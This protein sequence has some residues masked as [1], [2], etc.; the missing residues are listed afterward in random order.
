V[1]IH[2][3]G[4]TAD[5]SVHFHQVHLDDMVRVRVRKDRELEEREVT[6]GEIGKGYE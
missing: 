5:H 2:V 4:A 6:Q 1:P 3:V